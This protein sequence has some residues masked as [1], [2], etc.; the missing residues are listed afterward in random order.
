MLLLRCKNIK[1]LK[2][3]EFQRYIIRMCPLSIWCAASDDLSNQAHTIKVTKASD[4]P[5][6]VQTSSYSPLLV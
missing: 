2:Y 1:C 4:R 5:Y 6:N 3:V